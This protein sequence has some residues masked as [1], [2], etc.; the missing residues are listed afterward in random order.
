M[1][2]GGRRPPATRR[3]VPAW[4]RCSS[5]RAAA[6]RR[7]CPA[8][9]AIPPSGCVL[10][11][12]WA[13]SLND[14]HRARRARSGRRPPAGSPPCRCPPWTPPPTPVPPPIPPSNEQWQASMDPDWSM[15]TMSATSGCFPIAD[16]HVDRQRLLEGRLLVATRAIAV[17]SADHD[18]ALAKV[19]TIQR[20]HWRSVRR[21]RGTSTRTTLSYVASEANSVGSA[22][23]TMVSTFC[24]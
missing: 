8:S 22:S 21:L 15:T 16:A 10:T 14:T 18:Q 2:P 17:R 6:A 12:Q 19:P 4:R 23:G 1:A 9:H 13:C 11:T 24:C 5:G 7:S 3:P 20:G